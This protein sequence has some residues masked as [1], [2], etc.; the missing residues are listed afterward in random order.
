M[1]NQKISLRDAKFASARSACHAIRRTKL[2]QI[3][4]CQSGVMGL[5]VNTVRYALYIY[6]CVHVIIHV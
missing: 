3:Q 4:G 6:I 1:L 2:V 5:E